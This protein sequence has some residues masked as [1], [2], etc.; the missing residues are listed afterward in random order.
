MLCYTEDNGHCL[1][2]FSGQRE[3]KS[4]QRW[5]DLLRAEHLDLALNLL[6]QNNLPT[7]LSQLIEINS[8]LF[9]EVE[10][11]DRIKQ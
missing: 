3:N 2:K 4:S 9:L 8:Q 7:A 11:F 5:R 1:V 10:L 6:A